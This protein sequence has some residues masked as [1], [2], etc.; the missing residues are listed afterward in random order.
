[1][2]APERPGAVFD[3]M[4]F[5]QATARPSGPAAA[6]LRLVDT[7]ALT[8]FVSADLLREVEDVLSRR[9][10]GRRIRF[11]PTKPSSSCSIT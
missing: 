2:T 5:L 6:C 3:C 7:G 10:C 1:M 11:S 9:R 4:T 8:L